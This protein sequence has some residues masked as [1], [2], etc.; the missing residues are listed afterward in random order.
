MR[1]E[2][3]KAPRRYYDEHVQTFPL[4][5]RTAEEALLIMYHSALPHKPTQTP[6]RPRTA[7]RRKTHVSQNFRTVPLH[8]TGHPCSLADTC[9]RERGKWGSFR[10]RSRPIV[11]VIG[12]TRSP[13][14]CLAADDSL[15]LPDVDKLSHAADTNNSNSYTASFENFSTY[16]DDL[17]ETYTHTP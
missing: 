7:P 1:A 13:G 15:G 10:C 14:L 16:H 11:V 6:V 2:T 4:C 8:P 5:M 17:H 3:R 9:T 12:R